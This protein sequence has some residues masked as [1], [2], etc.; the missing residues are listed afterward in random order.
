M[1]KEEREGQED[2]IELEDK[3]NREQSHNLSFFYGNL[4][5]SDCDRQGS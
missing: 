5:P 3:R 1:S 4:S 2:W